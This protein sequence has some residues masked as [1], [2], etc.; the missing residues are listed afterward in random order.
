MRVSYPGVRVDGSSPPVDTARVLNAVLAGRQNIVL[1]LG[2]AAD[3]TVTTV[4]DDRLTETALPIAVLGSSV[5]DYTWLEPGAGLFDH[6]AGP[7]RIEPVIILM[8]G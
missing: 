6:A 2:I 3:A 5:T 8:G 7:A 1:E 4:R